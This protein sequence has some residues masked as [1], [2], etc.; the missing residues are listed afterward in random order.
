MIAQCHVPLMLMLV[1]CCTSFWLSLPKK[2]NGA[3]Y[4]AIGVTWCWHQYQWHDLTPTLIPMVWLDQKSHAV[5]HF[6]CLDLRNLMMPL[7]VPSV[8]CNANT[9]VD[10]ITYCNSLW[11]SWP[12]EFYVMLMPI[13]SNDQKVIWPKEFSGSI[14]TPFAY[15]CTLHYTNNVSTLQV[16]PMV[17]HEQRSHATPH[18]NHLDLMNSLVPLAVSLA[19]SDTDASV[20]KRKKS[21]CTSF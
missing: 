8:S 20:V 4:Y 11:S 14:D 15:I 9:N 5:P 16:M 7:T 18:F 1:S 13:A 21:C 12:K 17:S 10:S 6:D 3:I 2:C 19:S